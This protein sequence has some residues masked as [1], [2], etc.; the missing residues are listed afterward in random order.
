MENE[1]SALA[2]TLHKDP[3]VRKLLLDLVEEIERKF[4]FSLREIAEK[5][6]ISYNKASRIVERFSADGSLRIR[7]VPR[8][9]AL[10]LEPILVI[11]NPKDGAWLDRA[12]RMLYLKC[13]GTVYGGGRRAALLIVP[14]PGTIE[15][16]LGYIE[17]EVGPVEEHFMLERELISRPDLDLVEAEGV[18]WGRLRPV[19]IRKHVGR[20]AFDRV[21]LEALAELE[22]SGLKRLTELSRILGVNRKTLEYRL[23]TRV[24]NLLE[25]FSL[26]LRLWPRELA[27]ESLFVVK[28]AEQEEIA[29]LST[30]PYPVRTLV[31]RDAAVVLIQLPCREKLGFLERI[32]EIGEWKEYY[33]S[34]DWGVRSVPVEAL[35][36]KSAW[37]TRVSR[38]S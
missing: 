38:A 14:P 26:E 12:K 3:R 5:N 20:C 36:G 2:K 18:P 29:T 1:A 24:K 35:V 9:P 13:F 33:L 17:R 28:G 32:S 6:G 16:N 34:G 21:D 19:E 10:G 37:T 27:P 11:A 23:R 8:Y 15:D 4:T 22:K 7:A 30:A 31:G 25:G